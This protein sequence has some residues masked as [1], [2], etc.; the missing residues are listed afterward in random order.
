MNPS[1]RTGGA[2]KKDWFLPARSVRKSARST[3]VERALRARLGSEFIA[4]KDRTYASI[5]HI[6]TGFSEEKE[7]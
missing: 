3:Q 2:V 7:S 4:G 5:F 1:P 6:S